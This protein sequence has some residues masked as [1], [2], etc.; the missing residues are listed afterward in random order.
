MRNIKIGSR[1]LMAASF[2]DKAKTVCD[3]GCD[4]GKLS[5]Y[6][7]KEG[8]A[9]RIIAT[10][11]NEQPLRKAINLFE[12]NGLSDVAQ[13]VQTDGLS[14]IENTED[15]T[16][17]VIAGL[18]GGTMADVIAE[19]PFIKKQKTRLVLLPAQNGF[20]IRRYLY[21]NGFEIEKEENVMEKGKY[22]A[23]IS[24]V[25]TGKVTQATPFRIYIG[26]SRRNTDSAAL[27]YMK[28]ILSRLEKKYKGIEIDTGIKD[29]SFAEAVS[30]TK[31]LIN[32][33]EN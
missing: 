25:Y 13:F 9:E 11:I 4:H 28:M 19:A 3:V 18:G 33:I 29:E 26:E 14:G 21:E 16:H 30:K 17:I 22:Y 2:I 24:A 23:C 1:L 32:K 31:E 8:K 27:G 6:L 10:D 5:L 12:T 15:I 7:I 20:A